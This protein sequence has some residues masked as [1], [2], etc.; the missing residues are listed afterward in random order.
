M[1]AVSFPWVDGRQQPGIVV[2]TVPDD[3]DT[4]TVDQVTAIDT[5]TV[6]TWISSSGEVQQFRQ[7]GTPRWRG[8]PMLP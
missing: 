7:N 5:S 8:L 3:T 2:Y 6:I 4:A 1:K